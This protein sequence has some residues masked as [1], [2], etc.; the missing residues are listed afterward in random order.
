MTVNVLISKFTMIEGCKRAL[1]RMND[2]G[3]E[4]SS[5]PQPNTEPDTGDTLINRAMLVWSTSHQ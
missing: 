2:P 4:L 3:S 1:P 5:L